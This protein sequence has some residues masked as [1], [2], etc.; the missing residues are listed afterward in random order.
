[1]N[2]DLAPRPLA[3]LEMDSVLAVEQAMERRAHG[4]KPW[5]T[6][7]YLDQVAAVHARYTVRREWLR[8]HPQEVAA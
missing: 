4:L 6:D 2:A 1:M 3:D 8:T 5:T 7:E